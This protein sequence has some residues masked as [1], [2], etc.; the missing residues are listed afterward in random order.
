METIMYKAI[1]YLCPKIY[2]GLNV[3]AEILILN[4]F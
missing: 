2:L 4:G 1:F 3:E